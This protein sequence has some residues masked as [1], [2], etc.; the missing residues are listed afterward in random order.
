VPRD[1]HG[2]PLGDPGIDEDFLRLFVD[3]RAAFSRGFL[4]YGK[5]PATLS[6]IL[7]LLPGA[8]ATEV[9]EQIRDDPASPLVAS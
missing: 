7:A 2:H 6:K 8:S 3:N 9:R 4:S 1:L 5:P